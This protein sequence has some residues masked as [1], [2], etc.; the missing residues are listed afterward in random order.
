MTLADV[1]KWALNSGF[2]EIHENLLCCPYGDSS[3]QIELRDRTVAVSVQEGG[4]PEHKLASVRYSQLTMNEYGM[5]EGVGLV[6]PFLA[7]VMDGKPHPSWFSP[8]YVAAL[9]ATGIGGDWAEPGP[10]PV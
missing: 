10:E 6:S 9:A 2:S 8:K 3:V 5:I 1:R 4:K 7:A